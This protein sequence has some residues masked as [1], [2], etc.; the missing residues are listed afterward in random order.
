MSIGP[1]PSLGNKRGHAE[2]VDKKKIMSQ[3]LQVKKC[4]VDWA[5]D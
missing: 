4:S 1:L 2:V 5:R 3:S